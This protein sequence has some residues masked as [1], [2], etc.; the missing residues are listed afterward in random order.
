MQAASTQRL[1]D[2]RGA[3]TAALA[4]ALFVSGLALGATLVTNGGLVSNA[5]SVNS[6]A[7]DPNALSLQQYRKLEI[8]LGASSRATSPSLDIARYIHSAASPSFDV[9]HH[10][11]QAAPPLLQSDAAIKVVRDHRQGE[12]GVGGP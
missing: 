12:F 4:I 5:A 1:V 11:P 10:L 6:P 2:H 3:A 9:A 7:F 8:S